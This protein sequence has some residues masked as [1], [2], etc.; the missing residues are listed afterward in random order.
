MTRSKL[1]GCQASCLL[2]FAL[3]AVALL[4]PESALISRKNLQAKATTLI[5]LGLL[6][7]RRAAPAALRSSQSA[8]LLPPPPPPTTTTTTLEL[9]WLLP[10]SRA[11]L[12]IAAHCVVRRAPPLCIALPSELAANTLEMGHTK[13][14][15][16]LLLLASCLPACLL[17][18]LPATPALSA[19]CANDGFLYRYHCSRRRRRNRATHSIVLLFVVVVLPLS[20]KPVSQQLTYS[21][22]RTSACVRS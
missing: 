4:D 13:I 14:Q 17:T 20:S 15:G 6:S 22:R 2:E 12:V 19:M 8:D 18:Y 10:A 1:T 21:R 16:C 5:S 3:E 7:A 11:W 9:T